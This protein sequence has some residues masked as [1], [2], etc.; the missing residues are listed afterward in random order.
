MIEFVYMVSMYR[1]ADRERHSYPLGVFADPKT[2]VRAAETE[3]MIRDHQYIAEVLKL[4]V[5]Q[6]RSDLTQ[7]F[8]VIKP[9]SSQSPLPVG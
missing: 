5:N 2:A 6:S 9:L 3:E 8:T 4:P 1:G 7:G